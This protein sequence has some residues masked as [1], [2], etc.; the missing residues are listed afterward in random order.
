M[1]IT[2]VIQHWGLEETYLDSF[3]PQR[4]DHTTNTRSGEWE[5]SSVFLHMNANNPSLFFM[6][7][8]SAVLLVDKNLPHKGS[9]NTTRLIYIEYCEP[10]YF[11][12]WVCLHFLPFSVFQSLQTFIV[13]FPI[14]DIIA[15][16]ILR[17]NIYIRYHNNV[18]IFW[19]LE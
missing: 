12:S 8:L 18:Q 7:I 13:W 19:I 17:E 6:F 11:K 4:F 3:H 16:A 15:S 5:K 1:F 10:P 14:F 2:R 9:T